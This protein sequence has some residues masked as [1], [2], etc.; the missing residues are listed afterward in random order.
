MTSEFYINKINDLLNNKDKV[1]NKDTVKNVMKKYPDRIP[2]LVYPMDSKQPQIDKSK[3]LVP[4]D[5]LISQFIFIIKKRL[6]TVKPEEAIFLFVNK[7]TLPKSTDTMSELYQ[8][9]KN[10]DNFLLIQYSL[11]N[12]FG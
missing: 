10:E 12:T 3:Y 5:M 11:E 6:T 8:K 2:V 7:D 9:Y 4:K 1:L